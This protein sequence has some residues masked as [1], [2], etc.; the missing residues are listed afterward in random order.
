M[1]W[2]Q[3]LCKFIGH[4]WGPEYP[5]AGADHWHGGA[6]HHARD[7]Q[8]PGCRYVLRKAPS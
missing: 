6:G 4:K 8:R 3:F 2:A 1:T 5:T 7:C